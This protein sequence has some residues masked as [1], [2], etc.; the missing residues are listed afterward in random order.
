MS[1]LRIGVLGCGRIGRMHAELIAGRVEGLALGAV[2]TMDEVVAQ[3]MGRYRV[4]GRFYLAFAGAALLLATLGIY[5]VLSFDVASRTPEIGV[6]RALGASG[7]TVW[8][9]VVRSAG[10]RIALGAVL[11][12]GLGRWLSHGIQHVLYSVDIDDVTVFVAVA[13]LLTGV[14]ALASWIPARRATRIDPLTA[15]RAD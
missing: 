1:D 12:L 7:S 3:R 13:L 2:R 11:G 5:G 6:R 10:K 15:I 8:S 4:W 9:A 14:G